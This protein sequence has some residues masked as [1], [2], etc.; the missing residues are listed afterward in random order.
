MFTEELIDKK[1]L[2]CRRVVNEEYGTIDF[3]SNKDNA[4]VLRTLVRQSITK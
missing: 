2:T 4:I 3:V 1:L